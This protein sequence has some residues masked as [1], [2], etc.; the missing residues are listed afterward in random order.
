[1]A[2]QPVKVYID[3]FPILDLTRFEWQI[4]EGTA[5]YSTSFPL[6]VKEANELHTIQKQYATSNI[7]NPYVTLTMTDHFDTTLTFNNIYV[8]P[9]EPHPDPRFLNV[10]IVDSRYFWN[11]LYFN[12]AYNVR[13]KIGN[14]S[15][16]STIDSE[17]GLG[18]LPIVVF[19][20][21]A[22]KTFSLN[23]VAPPIG[24]P[25]GSGGVGAGVGAGGG[26]VARRWGLSEIIL[27]I[28]NYYKDSPDMP[29]ISIATD[30]SLTEFD[31]I[32]IE[33]IWLDSDIASALNQ[34]LQ[35]AG[36]LGVFVDNLGVVRFF[37]RVS[38]EH[39]LFNQMGVSQEPN[40]YHIMSRGDL[41]SP[42]WI[43]VLFTKEM[44]VRFD[45]EETLPTGPSESSTPTDNI[46]EEWRTLHNV[47][48]CP[49]P[50]ITLP[51][52]SKAVS[53]QYVRFQEIIPAFKTEDVTVGGVTTKGIS[54]SFDD[55]QVNWP[56]Q[57]AW[58]AGPA[59]LHGT[60]PRF[61]WM[62]R[63][64]C[65]KQNYRQTFQI[66][67]RWLDK[68]IGII[69]RR[70]SIIDYATGTYTPSPVYQNYAVQVS[71]RGLIAPG[72]VADGAMWDY[73]FSFKEFAESGNILES[74]ICDVAL[75]TFA[76]VDRGVFKI[77]FRNDPLEHYEKVFP[78]AVEGIPVFLMG[79]PTKG[80]FTDEAG[81]DASK[82]RL[83]PTHKMATIITATPAPTIK[84]NLFKIIVYPS[85]LKSP[86]TGT[87]I[88]PGLF[89]K[90]KNSIGPPLQ[91]KAPQS[92]IT[93]R[94]AWSDE[95]SQSAG[96]EASFGVGPGDP[97]AAVSSITN[98]EQ[99]LEVARKMAAVEWVRYQDRFKGG[100][101]GFFK[102][103][104]PKGTISRIVFRVESN[105]RSSTVLKTDGSVTTPN[106]INL[107]PAAL[108][109]FYHK[110][111][112]SKG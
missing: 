85:E 63:I 38:G 110:Q 112:D 70:V 10:T 75:L 106:F 1:M 100:K 45:F 16:Q 87:D 52:G 4:T 96:I 98:I 22:Y 20:K 103:L 51:D 79:H 94:Y 47:M 99:L 80:K 19:D 25:V 31:S 53:G 97:D 60:E 28:L 69:P 37:N 93:A 89:E 58:L 76:D 24:T 17:A 6:R 104:Y 65:I 39:L 3:K 42:K 50:I 74:K 46:D 86:T 33:N 81:K 95:L 43:E 40:E 2:G 18:P 73:W 23:T 49:D 84:G 32:F 108:R 62:N 90:I 44:E 102:M 30:E 57:G 68:M 9:L 34:V 59:G 29:G 41:A 92:N 11:R 78:S 61:L 55:I 105:G 107:L 26:A 72:A 27:H 64:N 48:P 82:L 101:E 8:L 71:T 88:I 77:N 12:H 13:N 91:I 54:V 56:L 15:V 14:R 21:Y 67:K 66:N 5:P 109:A 35:Y 7:K 36:G 111:V 83:T